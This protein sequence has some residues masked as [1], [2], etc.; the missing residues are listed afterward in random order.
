MSMHVTAE[1]IAKA[2]PGFKSE[3]LI[4]GKKLWIPAVVAAAPADGAK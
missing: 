2:N 1:Q 4:I 3:R